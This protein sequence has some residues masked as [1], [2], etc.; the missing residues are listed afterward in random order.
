MLTNQP[1]L[2]LAVETRRKS[3]AGRTTTLVDRQTDRQHRR[4]RQHDTWATTAN[5]KT[6][7][8]AICFTHFHFTELFSGVRFQSLLTRVLILRRL[9]E[10]NFRQDRDFHT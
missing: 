10:E 4:Q 1:N 7:K 8:N 6:D 9:R 3:L 5:D 2:L